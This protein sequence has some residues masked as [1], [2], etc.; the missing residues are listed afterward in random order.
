MAGDPS[1]PQV[2]ASSKPIFNSLGFF[3]YDFTIDPEQNL[4]VYVC[5]TSDGRSVVIRIR[6]LSDN[7]PHPL[8]V[9]EALNSNLVT[10]NRCRYDIRIFG[11]FIGVLAMTPAFSEEDRFWIWN[12]KTGILQCVS[13]CNRR[14]SQ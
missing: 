10:H 5:R 14:D 12:W 4:A 3:Y 7:A 6:Q 8:A 2:D 9:Y 1:L 13:A 11:D